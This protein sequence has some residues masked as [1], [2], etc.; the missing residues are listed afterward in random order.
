MRHGVLGGTFDPVHVGHLDVA[1]AAAAALALDDIQVMPS[2]IP[3]HRRPPQAPPDARLEMVRLAIAGEPRF[4]ASD[5]ELRSEGPSY[6]TA[7]LDRLQAS[8]VDLGS[9]FLITGADAF[10]DIATWKNYPAILDRCHFVAVS[11][12]GFPASR[13]RDALP[14]LASRMV[15]APGGAVPARPAIVLV[16]APTAPV[17][18]TDIRQRLAKGQSIDGLVPPAVAAYIERQGLYRSPDVKEQNGQG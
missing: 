3:P 8:G 2:R 12:P 17:S 15:E 9:V 1:R 14:A 11:R 16:D 13:L 18:S 6:T 4:V 7:T 10:R 5:L